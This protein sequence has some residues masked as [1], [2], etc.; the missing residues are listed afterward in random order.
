[1][2]PRPC[3]VPPYTAAAQPSE[4]ATAIVATANGWRAD[5]ALSM[6]VNRSYIV[7]HCCFSNRLLKT[8]WISRSFAGLGVIS[9]LETGT[10]YT[11]GGTVVLISRGDRKRSLSF[12]L[13]C[14]ARL[15]RPSL[16]LKTVTS[17]HATTMSYRYLTILM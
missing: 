12:L 6:A 13:L 5:P 1:V 8:Q 9:A 14:R 16:H 10:S 2:L 11:V 15:Y 17:C 4:M 7:Y 3:P